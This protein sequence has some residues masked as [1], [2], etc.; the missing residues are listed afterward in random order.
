MSPAFH[1]RQ[2]SAADAAMLAELIREAFADVAARYRLTP[3]NCPRHPSNCQPDWMHEGLA[4]GVSFFVLES[5][6]L[7][8]GCVGMTSPK[9]GACEL[10]RLAVRPAYRRGGLGRALVEHVI[11]LARS[12][13]LARVDLGFH[14][15]SPELRRWYE[16]CG[17]VLT[18][19]ERPAH[20]LFEVG[21]MSL[22]LAR[23]EGPDRGRPASRHTGGHSDAEAPL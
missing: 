23:E 15:G 1:I 4:K 16:K 5:G 22:R 7:P 2:A 21:F 17:F 13:G 20:L 12:R 6:G 10:V 3:E 14:A 18:R 9:D 19:V 8:C 11:G